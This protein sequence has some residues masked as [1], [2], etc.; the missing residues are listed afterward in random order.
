MNPTIVDCKEFEFV[1]RGTDLLAR[2]DGSGYDTNDEAEGKG[3]FEVSIKKRELRLQAGGYVGVVPINDRL[4]LRIHPRAPI[5]NVDHIVRASGHA[6]IKI[7]GLRAYEQSDEI[8]DW[9]YDVY[10]S[11]LEP[12]IA[13]LLERG[14]L[15]DYRR[16]VAAGSSPRGRVDFGRTVTRFAARGIDSRC[17]YSWFERSQDNAP[18]QLIK[19]ALGVLR[20]HYGQRS[21]NPRSGDVSRMRRLAGL[22]ASFEHIADAPATAVLTAPEVLDPSRIPDERYYYREVVRAA[23]YLVS[24]RGISLD[25]QGRGLMLDSLLIDMSD[26]FEK[27]V[28]RLLMGTAIADSWPVVVLDGNLEPGKLPLYGRPSTAVVSA[29][30]VDRV[31][32]VG[33]L[34]PDATPDIVLRDANTGSTRLIGEVKYTL[35]KSELP[36]RSEVEQALAYAHTHDT[37]TILLVHPA[38]PNRSRGLVF[39]GTIGNVRI[40]DYRFNMAAENLPAEEADWC[41]AVRQL[42]ESV[43]VSA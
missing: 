28:R 19:L 14:L 26:V 33:G 29:Y 7:A 24:E 39:V 17:E 1:S 2:V 5:A 18:N 27:Y 34:K 4:S 23:V 21:K 8:D 38:M 20:S 9:L 11:F 15:R 30:G 35:L 3:V 31:S 32:R 25:R 36:P 37:E 6:P 12:A 10:A 22:S 42:A 13:D 43:V 40:F 41:N 16:V